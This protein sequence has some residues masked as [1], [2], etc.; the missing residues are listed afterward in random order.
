MNRSELETLKAIAIEARNLAHKAY[1][2]ALQNRQAP[3]DTEPAYQALLKANA[4]LH[5]IDRMIIAAI[6]AEVDAPKPQPTPVVEL[7][8]VWY[9]TSG[10]RRRTKTV[11]A[12]TLR[13][14]ESATHL[15]IRVTS[16]RRATDA[17][18]ARGE[19]RGVLN[20]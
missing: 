12:D 18:V 15:G 9:V 3:G 17:E 14:M 6:T 4:V 1:E 5:S 7:H 20:A 13:W 16:S 2:V 11:A 10:L 8:R 19:F